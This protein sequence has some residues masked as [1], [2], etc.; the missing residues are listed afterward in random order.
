M[1]SA[2]GAVLFLVGCTTTSADATTFCLLD[3]SLKQPPDLSYTI[4]FTPE[5]D[6]IQIGDSIYIYKVLGAAN[7]DA[8]LYPMALAFPKTGKFSDEAS[9]IAVGDNEFDVVPLPGGEM[10]LVSSKRWSGK[11]FRESEEFR[12]AMLFSSRHGALAIQ[13]AYRLSSG[14]ITSQNF[15]R[16]GDTSRPLDGL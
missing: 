1:F 12:S 5:T 4:V 10:W 13:I 3:E 6:A 15:V 9:T 16:C 14:L 11:T 2:I 8:I 7:A